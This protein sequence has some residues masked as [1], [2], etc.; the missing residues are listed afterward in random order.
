MDA[1]RADRLW[2][3]VIAAMTANGRL[4]AGS[5]TMTPAEI[6]RR[7]RSGGDDRLRVLV[8]RYYYPVRYGHRSGTLSDE[9]AEL[10]VEAIEGG[11]RAAGR[12]AETPPGESTTE[13]CAICGRRPRRRG[14]KDEH[15]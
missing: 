15:R 11:R 3:R 9:Q 13:L 8:E 4:P 6:A 14:G 7:V 10:I 2:R 1:E 5:A 12:G